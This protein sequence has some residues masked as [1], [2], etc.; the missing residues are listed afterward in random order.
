[1]KY[2]RIIK[3]SYKLLNIA[4]IPIT[5][6]L[7]SVYYT[8]VQKNSEINLKYIELAID[9]LK[10]PSSDNNKYLKDYAKNIIKEYSEI[11]LSKEVEEEIK[12]INFFLKKYVLDIEQKI[13]DDWKVVKN[14]TIDDLE[15]LA[16][17]PSKH[18]RW[19]IKYPYDFIM[20]E[21][22][23]DVFLEQKAD[24]T[25]LDFVSNEKRKHHEKYNVLDK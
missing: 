19:N 3:N 24:K 21:K 18:I 6:A 4:I 5:I 16:P 14:I 23:Y 2:K 15:K 12:N 17:I 8:N 11:P 20:D 7:V 22:H 10:Q 1:M 9:I 25:I 13:D